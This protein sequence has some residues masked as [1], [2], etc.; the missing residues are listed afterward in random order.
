MKLIDLETPE[1]NDFR[2]VSE[3]S[4]QKGI[5]SPFRPDITILINGIPMGFWK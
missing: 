2:V 5:V 3:L 4:Y 1:N